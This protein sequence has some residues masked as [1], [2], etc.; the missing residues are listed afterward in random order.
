MNIRLE[1]LEKEWG[2]AGVN[3]ALMVLLG[4]YRG[5]D[6]YLYYFGGHLIIT[7]FQYTPKPYCNYKGPYSMVRVLPGCYKGATEAVVLGVA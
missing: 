5:L 1:D 7:I 3:G 2:H 6:N 4:Y